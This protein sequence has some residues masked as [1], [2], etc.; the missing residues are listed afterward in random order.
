MLSIL[1][2]TSHNPDF[3]KLTALFDEYL[4]YIDGDEKAEQVLV[5][6]QEVTAIPVVTQSVEMTPEEYRAMIELAKNAGPED[7]EMC[8]S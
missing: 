2:T 4:V 1:R 8:G 5:Q 7:C 6:E 3:Q